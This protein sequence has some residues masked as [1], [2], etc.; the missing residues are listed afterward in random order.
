[1]QSVSKSLSHY[2]DSKCLLQELAATRHML[3]SLYGLKEDGDR[4]RGRDRDRES[5]NKLPPHHFAKRQA[6][7]L[8][9]TF[10]QQVSPTTNCLF[11][12]SPVGRL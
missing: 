12:A 8:L 6:P 1:M 10:R 4:D 2:P 5:R 3:N 7:Q 9:D 11:I